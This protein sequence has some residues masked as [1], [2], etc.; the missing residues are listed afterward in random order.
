MRWIVGIDTRN[1]SQGALRF[2]AWLREQ[3]RD[4]EYEAHGFHVLE[5]DEMMVLLRRRHLAEVLEDADKRMREAIE[6][7]NAGDALSRAAVEQAQTAE[8]FLADAARLHNADGLIIG[9]SAMREGRALVRLGRVARRLVRSLPAPVVV[10][11]PDLDTGQLGDGPVVCAVSPSPESVDAARTAVALAERLG[12]KA[13]L[14]HCLRLGEGVSLSGF[15]DELISLERKSAE[16][17]LRTF[18]EAHELTDARREVIIGAPED[19]VP[20]RSVELRAPII[21]CG[22]RR[23]DIVQ[24][25]FQSS[26]GTHLASY[27]KVPVVVV[28]PG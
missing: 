14:V 8:R 28:P 6:T 9:R 15:H 5:H 2:A 10:T 18:C 24:R 4:E 17:R 27:S 23:L 26:V 21:V 12:R 19:N 11:P 20:T 16:Q 7:A 3:M 13:V 22:S 25:V 1:R